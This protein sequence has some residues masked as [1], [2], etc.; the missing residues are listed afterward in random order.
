MWNSVGKSIRFIASRLYDVGP[1]VIPGRCCGKGWFCSRT[2]K[3]HI[4]LEFT[5]AGQ[6]KPLD[7]RESLTRHAAAYPKALCQALAA[8]LRTAILDKVIDQ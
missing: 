6:Q 4:H 2:G 7:I 1:L 8:C 3:R 5:P